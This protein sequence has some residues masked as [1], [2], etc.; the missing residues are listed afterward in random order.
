MDS[1]PA[2]SI[3]PIPIQRRLIFRVA[4]FLLML[5]TYAGIIGL[6]LT[7][8]RAEIRDSPASAHLWETYFFF[9]QLIML[10]I[11]FF[12]MY[13][14]RKRKLRASAPRKRTYPLGL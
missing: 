5:V 14:S 8:L 9:I 7:I 2:T 12:T 11:P 13:A 1:S 10:G 4:V 6:S 3:Q